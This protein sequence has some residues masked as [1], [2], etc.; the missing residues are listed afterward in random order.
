M[1][2]LTIVNCAN[3]DTKSHVSTDGAATGKTQVDNTVAVQLAPLQH[4]SLT[5]EFVRAK[6]Q[7]DV[8]GHLGIT[9]TQVLQVT[10]GILKEVRFDPGKT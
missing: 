4:I 6:L 7:S 10:N 9:V 3:A 5:H 2:Y 1:H 8:F